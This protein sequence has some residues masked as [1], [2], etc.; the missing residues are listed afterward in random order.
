MKNCRRI[1]V[2]KIINFIKLKIR[3][4]ISTEKLIGLGL[5]VGENF[6]RQEKCI[7]DFSHC[8]LITI[9]DNV[10]LAP[11]VHILAHDASTKYHLNYTKVGKVVIGNNVFIGANT[12]ILPNVEIGDNVIVG[13]GSVV[14]K[15]VP[16]G[17]VVGGNPAKIITSTKEY[18]EKNRLKMAEANLFDESWTL[19]ENISESKKK[20][21]SLLLQ[22][23]IGF[24]K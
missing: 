16:S 10:T 2:K 9:K 20:E 21:M 19:R 3:G 11:G 24:V 4:E 1:V 22:D 18:I 15:S 14:T 6:Q 17:F 23:K 7:I 8:W 13:A 5:K 12:T